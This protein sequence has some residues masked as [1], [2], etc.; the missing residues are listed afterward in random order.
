MNIVEKFVNKMIKK[1]AWKSTLS[2]NKAEQN[3]INQQIKNYRWVIKNADNV[4]IYDSDTDGYDG[5]NRYPII[6][7][8]LEKIS[9]DEKAERASVIGSRK[10]CKPKVNYVLDARLWSIFPDNDIEKECLAQFS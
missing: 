2:S 7:E 6:L 10:T 1:V 3:K 8:I 4:L 9:E 5:L